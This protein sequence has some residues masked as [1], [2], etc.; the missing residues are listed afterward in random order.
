M[1][2]TVFSWSGHGRRKAIG[3]GG[4]SR[5][6]FSFCAAM[7]VS[8]RQSRHLGARSKYIHL[9]SEASKMF[10]RFGCL[11]CTLLTDRKDARLALIDVSKAWLI[12]CKRGILK[13]EKLEASKP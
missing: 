10:P 3:I 8:V 12:F 13:V 9:R 4:D 2:T 5:S 6:G 1:Y 7:L 11:S